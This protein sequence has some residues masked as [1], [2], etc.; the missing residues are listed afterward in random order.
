MFAQTFLVHSSTNDNNSGRIYDTKNEQRGMPVAVLGIVAEYNPFHN[1]HLYLMEKAQQEENFAAII[2][3]MSGNFLQRGEPA[4]CDKWSRAEMALSCGA[5]L[6]IELPFGFAARSAY[7]FARG[8]LQLLHRTGVVT[9]LAFGVESDNLPLLKNIAGIISSEPPEYKTILK[10]H[11]SSGLS[12]PLS[13]S[14]ALQEYAGQPQ[15]EWQ[16]TM[17]GPNN[18]LALEYLHVIAKERLPFIPLAINR[19]GSSY[20]SPEL[21]QYSSA[22]AIRQAL[23]GNV[24]SNEIAPS[25]PVP[26]LEILQREIAR[27]RAPI[28]ANM[29]EQAILYKLRTTP[30]EALSEIYEVSEGLE[31]RIKAAANTSGSL[32]ELRQSIKSKRYSLSRINRT[33][34]YS[35]FDL[36]KNQINSFDKEGPLYLHLLGFSAKGQKILQELKIKSAVKIFNR[37]SDMKRC[38]DE[39]RDTVLGDMIAADALATDVYS[40]LFPTPSAR[41]GGRDFTSSPVI[42]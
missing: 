38:Y 10:R 2:V 4:L 6:V 19:R 3:V 11:L 16:Q 1:G 42:V 9:H 8:A 41:A 22:T 37:G 32:E 40:L 25:L 26:C 23:L 12:F 24:H 31:F 33:L 36:S 29:L 39:T 18:I 28:Q 30:V 14:L 34:L 35:L 17:L 27:G 20:H 13:R 5:D 7:Y 15:S 21:S